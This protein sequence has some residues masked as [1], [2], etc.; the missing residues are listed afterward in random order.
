MPQTLDFNA[1]VT[2]TLAM[3]RRVLGENI[4]VETRLAPRLDP[5][6]ADPGQLEQVI[7]NLCVNVDERVPAPARVHGARSRERAGSA[8]A[9]PATPETGSRDRRRH[10]AD[11][12]RHGAGGAGDVPTA[13]PRADDVGLPAASQIFTGR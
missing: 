6:L 9:L 3:L 4:V 8:E 5:V 11:D 13:H 7:V 2:K 12:G 10:H 1:I